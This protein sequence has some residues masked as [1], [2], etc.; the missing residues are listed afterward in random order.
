MVKNVFG[1]YAKCIEQGVKCYRAVRSDGKLSRRSFPT[2]T[3]A[4]MY[5]WRLVSEY[6]RLTLNILLEKVHLT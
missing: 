6:R 4:K 3:L 5:H 1:E 2:A